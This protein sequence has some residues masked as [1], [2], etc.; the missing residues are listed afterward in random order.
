MSPT[1]TQL[2]RLTTLV[3]LSRMLTSELDSSEIVHQVLYSAID[4]IPAADAGTLYLYDDEAD[5]LRAMDSIGFGP[6]IFKIALDPGE[7]AAGRAFHLGHGEIHASPEAIAVT[8]GTASPETLKYFR[9]ASQGVRTPR[10]AMSAALVF[11]SKP[12]GALVVD[13]MREGP[14]FGKEDLE[15][16]E[17]FG[18]IAAVAI[19]N[20]RVYESEHASRVRLEVLNAEITRQRDELDRRLR[21]LDAMLETGRG[22]PDLQALTGK[23]AQLTSSRVYVLDGIARIRDVQPHGAPGADGEES[24]DRA[25]DPRFSKLV[26]RV[27]RA[28][29]RHSSS[30]DGAHLVASPITAGSEL[31]G[32][33][34]VD[35][36]ER[37]PDAVDEALV[38]SAALIASTVFVQEK[39]LEEGDF[40]RRSDLL[41]RLLD[42][43][44]PKSASSMRPLQPPLLLAVG[45]VRRATGPERGADHNVTRALRTMSWDALREALP[46]SVVD[47]RDDCVVIACSLADRD[48]TARLGEELAA[49]AARFMRDSPEWSVRFAV[50]EALRDPALVAQAYNEAHLALKIRPWTEQPVVEVAGLGAYRLIITSTNASYA[51]QFS[52]RVL[53]RVLEHDR[54]LDGKILSTFRAYLAAGASVTAAAKELDV[55]THTVQYRLAKLEELSGLSL[56][57]SEDRLTLELSLR[58]LD[59]LRP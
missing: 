1:R 14:A 2:D 47:V 21:A 13:A 42:G 36:D 17:D 33:V 26:E 40:R 52:Q 27:G 12:L 4:L 50:T 54:T 25:R 43:D 3:H 8:L 28:R 7:A 59:L 22:G 45:R 18:R 41:H 19:V 46:S 55:H 38:D 34:V 10:A 57:R 53:S 11:K 15:F 16:L 56:R 5:K 29:R 44:V 35:T 32:F 37:A 39:A 58:I 31:L 23:L 6:S 24:S 51:V 9:E 49:I 30:A 48:V 20:A